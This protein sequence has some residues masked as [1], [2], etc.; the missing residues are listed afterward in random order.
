MLKLNCA[1]S[2]MLVLAAGV[3]FQNPA[4]AQH[5]SP[6]IIHGGSP[7]TIRYDAG[8]KQIDTRTLATQ[9][10]DTTV[11]SVEVSVNGGA[12]R[13]I[14]FDHQRCEIRLRFGSI[15][16]AVLTDPKGQNLRATIFGGARFGKELQ[17]RPEGHYQSR[18]D[19]HVESLTIL[20]GGVSELPA[21]PISGPVDIVVKHGK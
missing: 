1:A 12:P 21:G 3:V 20:R 11:T 9:F 7:L 19:G 13:L 4:W 14:P 5:D 8:W 6:I 10:N 17:K 2:W 16:L 15:G 18:K